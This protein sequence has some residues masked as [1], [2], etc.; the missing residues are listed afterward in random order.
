MLD[1]SHTIDGWTLS[2]LVQQALFI[3]RRILL[4][5]QLKPKYLHPLMPVVKQMVINNEIRTMEMYSDDSG[6]FI[7]TLKYIHHREDIWKYIWCFLWFLIN[8]KLLENTNFRE[9]IN[10]MFVWLRTY[11]LTTLQSFY[12][13][14]RSPKVVARFSATNFSSY[15]TD[16][17]QL[18][19]AI[20]INEIMH[21]STIISP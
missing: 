5:N 20:Q 11:F 19:E 16:L 18:H 4:I 10:W 1:L 21:E 17:L 13:S 6:A 8:L 2:I 7:V 14:G 12:Q 9:S 3:H 15:I